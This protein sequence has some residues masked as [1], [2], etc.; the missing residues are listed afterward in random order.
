M[1]VLSAE[2]NGFQPLGAWS[3]SGVEAPLAL[4]LPDMPFLEALG[5]EEVNDNFYYVSNR[6]FRKYRTMTKKGGDYWL[7]SDVHWESCKASLD[8]SV[9]LSTIIKANNK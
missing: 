7:F 5:I 6:L 8:V 1:R 3:R 4:Y 9:D 2:F